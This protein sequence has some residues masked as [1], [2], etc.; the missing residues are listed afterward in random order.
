MAHESRTTASLQRRLI[1]AQGKAIQMSV[2][3]S[4]DRREA[5]A[6]IISQGLTAATKEA[7]KQARIGLDATADFRRTMAW[8]GSAK[9][10][11]RRWGEDAENGIT[12]D[13]V[14]ASRVTASASLGL[15]RSSLAAA[16]AAIALVV[17]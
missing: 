16:E 11:I 15:A 13:A 10:S 7:G 2:T 5:R 8:I 3:A 14:A 4:A 6:G 1:A 17:A 9:A 12:R